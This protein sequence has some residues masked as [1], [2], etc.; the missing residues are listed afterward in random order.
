MSID[1]CYATEISKRFCPWICFCLFVLSVTQQLTAIIFVLQM[2]V[3]FMFKKAFDLLK[4]LQQLA[5][6]ILSFIFLMRS[7]HMFFQKEYIFFS[8][9]TVNNNSFCIADERSVHV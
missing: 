3:L 5:L 2:S 7:D 6:L 9:L 4:G 1:L 8:D